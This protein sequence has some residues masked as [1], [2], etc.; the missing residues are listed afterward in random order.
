MSVKIARMQSG[1]DVIADIKEV[2]AD[3]DT[4]VPIAYEFVQA[5]SVMIEQPTE[6][7]TFLVEHGET[8]PS[9]EVD[10]KDV[11]LRLYP[12]SP[13]TTGRNIV[14]INSVVSISDPHENVLDVYHKTLKKYKPAAMSVYFDEVDDHA[15][16]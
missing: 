2:R 10:L 3:V 11:Q 6:Q 4:A 16:D 9:Q 7:Y 14:T 12:W 1:E 15:R 8:E 13:L 5:Y